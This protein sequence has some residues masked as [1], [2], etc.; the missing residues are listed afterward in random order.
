MSTEPVVSVIGAAE[1]CGEAAHDAEGWLT[2]GEPG[3]NVRIKLHKKT[4]DLVGWWNTGAV[5]VYVRRIVAPGDVQ[6]GEIVEIVMAQHDGLAVESEDANPS[7]IACPMC[8][9][10]GCESCRDEGFIEVP[11]AVSPW[12]DIVATTP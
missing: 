7:A 8:D 3:H 4:F 9:G 6:D 12:N 1:Y 5:S 2:I 11:L 10:D